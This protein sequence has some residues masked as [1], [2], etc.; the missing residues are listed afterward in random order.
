MISGLSDVSYLIRMSHFILRAHLFLPERYSSAIY[1]II[2]S[3]VFD[4]IA[5][6]LLSLAAPPFIIRNGRLS[7]GHSRSN[8]LIILWRILFISLSYHCI[9]VDGTVC[10]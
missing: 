1:A 4:F 8:H 5:P 9:F 2:Y 10:M 7:D 6:L 3:I